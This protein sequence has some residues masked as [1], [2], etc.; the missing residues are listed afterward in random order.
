[1]H[2]E[3]ILRF[4]DTCDS[5]M[6]QGEAGRY[7]SI[8]VR[9]GSYIPP[10]PD[11]V[12]PLMFELL[13]GGTSGRGPVA[14]TELGDTASPVRII[15]PFADGNGRTGRALAL[16]EFTGVVSIRTTFFRWMN[17]TGKTGRVITR[18]LKRV[19]R[20]G[21]DLTSLARILGGWAAGYA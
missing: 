1:M 15:H 8:Y 7:R 10:P 14:G 5:V 16:W 6:D 18:S 11:D 13:S 20:D 19:H 2:H 12:S 9:V 3:H 21:D 17:S 4:T